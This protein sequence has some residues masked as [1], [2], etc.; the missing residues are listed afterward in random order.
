MPFLNLNANNRL[1]QLFDG[2]KENTISKLFHWKNNKSV[3]LERCV[4]S[5][6]SHK[7]SI[8]SQK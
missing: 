5:L 6:D 4:A 2:G 7:K 1:T 3:T 8:P